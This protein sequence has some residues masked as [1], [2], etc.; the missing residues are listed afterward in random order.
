MG[1]RKISQVVV[2]QEAHK[3]LVSPFCDVSNIN[4]HFV[5]IS[6]DIIKW[7][8]SSFLVYC[9]SISKGA[10]S[11][12]QLFGSSRVIICVSLIKRTR[13][14]WHFHSLATCSSNR[15]LLLWCWQLEISSWLVTNSPQCLLIHKGTPIV[16]GGFY[17][18][19]SPYLQQ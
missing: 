12:Y 17:P 7:S 14:N 6:L 1:G 11:P 18:F 15:G 19:T 3:S 8:Y 16:K 13:Q 4:D 5:D 10:S 2:S 9:F